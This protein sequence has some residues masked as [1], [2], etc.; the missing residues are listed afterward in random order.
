MT[1]AWMR[2]PARQGVPIVLRARNASAE[3]RNIVPN[4]SVARPVAKEVNMATR[5]RPRSKESG[6]NGGNTGVLV[7][8]AVAGAAVGLA[9]NVGRKLFVQFA[10]VSAGDWFDALKA[11]HEAARALLDRLQATDDNQ[12]TARTHLL[13][14]LKHALGRHAI[15]EENVIYPAL[16]EADERQEADHL[17]SDHGYVKTYLYELEGL[18]KDSPAWPARLGEF[19]KMID[20]HMREEE[21]TIF[22]ALRAKLSAEK[23]AEITAL[24]NKEGFKAA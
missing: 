18:A 13:L 22:P 2:A 11:E 3:D 14:K 20:E 21:E 4:P 1:S 19:R 23:N 5:T 9:A 8:A 17:T 16:R 24:M 12:T 7:G 10:S 15:E 6:W